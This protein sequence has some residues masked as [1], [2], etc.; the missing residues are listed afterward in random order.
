MAVASVDVST[1]LFMMIRSGFAITVKLL[2]VSISVSDGVWRNGIGQD[3]K[4]VM[5]SS[6]IGDEP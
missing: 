2:S 3:G 4:M 5:G 1:K 6:S